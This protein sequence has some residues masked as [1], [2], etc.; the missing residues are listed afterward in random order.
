VDKLKTGFRYIAQTAQ[1]PIIPIGLALK[2]KR[3]RLAHL[4]GQRMNKRICPPFLP[5]CDIQEKILHDLRHLSD[6][7]PFNYSFYWFTY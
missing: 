5:F 3:C 6:F 4:V 7:Y 2:I 1:V